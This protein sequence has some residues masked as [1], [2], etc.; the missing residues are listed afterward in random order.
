MEIDTAIRDNVIAELDFEPSI[1]EAGIGVTVHNGVVT[2]SGH[3]PSYAQKIAAE[4]AAKRIKGVHAVAVD[5]EVRL[6]SEAKHDDEEIARRAASLLGWTANIGERVKAVVDGGWVTLS[7]E[8]PWYY[9]KQEAERLVRT[10]QGVRGVSNTITVRPAVKPSDIR[11]RITQAF[12]RNAE[13]ESDAIRVDVAGSTVTLS[14]KVKDW[15]ERQM[16]ETA[17]WAAPGVTEVRDNITL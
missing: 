10:L 17:A 3:V 9:Q 14:G 15:Y 7:G 8:A 1:E 6:P 16:A 12:K 4:N 11:D 2:L 13:L 5:I